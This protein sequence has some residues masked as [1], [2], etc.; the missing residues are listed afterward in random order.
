MRYGFLGIAMALMMVAVFTVS[1]AKDIMVDEGDLAVLAGQ[2]GSHFHKARESFLKG[3]IAAAAD[4]IRVA[5][6]LC[7]LSLPVPQVKG[8][9][10]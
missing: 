6:R 9:N 8:R 1:W 10:F 7:A 4:D 3:Y 2:A 5:M